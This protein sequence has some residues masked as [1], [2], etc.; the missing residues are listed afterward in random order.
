MT[1]EHLNY[2]QILTM[3]KRDIGGTFHVYTNLAHNLLI[4][5]LV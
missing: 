4:T 3:N 2:F 1:V 5:K